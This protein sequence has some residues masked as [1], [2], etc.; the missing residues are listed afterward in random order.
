M[1]VY[2]DI[3][4]WFLLT[5]ARELAVASD[6]IET[7]NLP[8]KM[9]L[10]HILPVRLGTSKI[11]LIQLLDDAV[12]RKDTKPAPGIELV[13]SANAWPTIERFFIEGDVLTA[14]LFEQG[15]YCSGFKTVYKRVKNHIQNHFGKSLSVTPQKSSPYS[16][17][18]WENNGLAC[19]LQVLND[20]VANINPLFWPRDIF[21][22]EPN[23]TF[24]FKKGKKFAVMPTIAIII[25]KDM[26]T[27]AQV[28]I[29]L[30]KDLAVRST[31]VNLLNLP[32]I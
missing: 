1:D 14:T 2:K 32:G 9:M 25:A 12:L 8:V 16:V 6:I 24:I 23:G 13:I 18:S 3:K 4:R 28:I 27:L 19:Y 5:F 31:C 26:R 22:S 29:F 10:S 30:Q 17:L 7:V 20:N 11:E 15:C 21:G